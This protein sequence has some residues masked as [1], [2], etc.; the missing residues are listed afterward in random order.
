MHNS[1]IK[2]LGE[3]RFKNLTIMYFFECKNIERIPDLSSSSNLTKLILSKCP[4][5]VEVHQSVGLLDKLITL[6]CLDCFKLRSF[7]NSLKLISLADLSL[8]GCESLQNFPEIDCEM[9]KV[10]CVDLEHSGIKELPSSIAY[11]TGLRSLRLAGCKNLGYPTDHDYVYKDSTFSIIFPGSTLPYWF[12]SC[13][14]NLDNNSFEINISALAYPEDISGMALNIVFGPICGIHDEDD[15]ELAYFETGI[16]VSYGSLYDEGRDL[17]WL[18]DPLMDVDHVWLKHIGTYHIECNYG[19]V[20]VFNQTTSM[21]IKS[22]GFYFVY[23]HDQEV[24]TCAADMLH[25]DVD[26]NLEVPEKEWGN[27]GH[28][29]DGVQLSKRRRSDD[30]RNRVSQWHHEHGDLMKEAQQFFEKFSDGYL[31]AVACMMRVMTK[32]NFKKTTEVA[33]IETENP[34][35]APSMGI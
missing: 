3:R 35:G 29:T 5:L 17:Y 23:K 4:N 19:R 33:M 8:D 22:Y 26:V 18:P 15:G 25:E 2:E 21:I 13:K 14:E 11:L 20:R 24:A 9:K 10:Q 28:L 27:S 16:F 30:D 31:V 12:H 6:R 7:P 32:F 1:L 34:N